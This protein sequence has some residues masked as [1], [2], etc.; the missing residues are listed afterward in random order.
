ML[1]FALIKATNFDVGLDEKE[2]EL[3]NKIY[4]AKLKIENNNIKQ[5]EFY[6]L[7]NYYFCHPCSSW[8]RSLNEYTNDLMR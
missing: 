4:T 1:N 5:V 7:E 6:P 3:I 8:E 2:L